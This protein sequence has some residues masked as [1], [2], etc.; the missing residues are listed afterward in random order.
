MRDPTIGKF[1][2]KLCKEPGIDYLKGDF[3]ALTSGL[4]QSIVLA[5]CWM[6]TTIKKHQLKVER[7]KFQ[8]KGERFPN[9]MTLVKHKV[10]I[11]SFLV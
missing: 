4:N 9:L 3:C 7:A 11:N 6:G 2:I 1:K 5:T 10:K 8:L